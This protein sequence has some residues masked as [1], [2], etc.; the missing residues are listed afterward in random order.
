MRAEFRVAQSLKKFFGCAQ[1]S[2]SSEAA[3]QTRDIILNLE[4]LADVAKLMDLV[5]GRMT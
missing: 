2:L 5:R 1:G 4:K 3:A